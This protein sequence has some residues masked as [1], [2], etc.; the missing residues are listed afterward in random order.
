[1]S[2]STTT[3]TICCA[4]DQVIDFNIPRTEAVMHQCAKS[5]RLFYA[6]LPFV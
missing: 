2:I 5:L 3:T 1:M 6:D 4:S